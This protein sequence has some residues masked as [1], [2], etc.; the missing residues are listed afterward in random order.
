MHKRRIGWHTL[1]YLLKQDSEMP[2]K[3]TQKISGTNQ[4]TENWI[5]KGSVGLSVYLIILILS[6]LKF[7][8]SDLNFF[9]TPIL[10]NVNKQ[11]Q[12]ELKEEEAQK[13]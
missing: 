8:I 1:V 11:L 12:V 5:G 4:N 10:I 7:Q 3:K 6:C 13:P 2:N 9:P